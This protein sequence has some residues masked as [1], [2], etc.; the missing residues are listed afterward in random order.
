[1]IKPKTQKAVAHAQRTL[2]LFEFD[3]PFAHILSQKDHHAHFTTFFAARLL[4][5]PNNCLINSLQL[6]EALKGTEKLLKVPL[7]GTFKSFSGF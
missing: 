4:T 7:R 2:Q 6:I 3:D 1:M 5:F